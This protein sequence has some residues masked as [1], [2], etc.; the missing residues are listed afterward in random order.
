MILY[1]MLC[2]YLPFED[3]NTNVLYKKIM[4][5]EYHL[6]KAISPEA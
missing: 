5:S 1:A 6:P 4:N 2:G 3:T